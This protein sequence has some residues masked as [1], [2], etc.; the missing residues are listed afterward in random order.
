MALILKATILA[1][2]MKQYRWSLKVYHKAAVIIGE[3][4][5]TKINIDT[6]LDNVVNECSSIIELY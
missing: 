2:G 5:G 1:K 3:I 6:L 4:T